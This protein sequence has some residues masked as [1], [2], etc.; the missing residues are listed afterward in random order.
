MTDFAIDYS[1]YSSLERVSHSG[2]RVD[3]HFLEAALKWHQGDEHPGFLIDYL[4]RLHRGGA[5][6]KTIN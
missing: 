4:E 2:Q 1:H 6:D 3:D 5:H